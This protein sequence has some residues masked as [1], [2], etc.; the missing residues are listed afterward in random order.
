MKTKTI[1]G[2]YS[3]GYS[4]SAN[5][6]GLTVAATG[7]IGGTGLLV[8]NASTVTNFGAIEAGGSVGANGA[9]FSAGGT[10]INEAGGLILG[11]QGRNGAGGGHAGYLGGAALVMSGLGLIT[12]Y[13]VMTGGQGGAGASGGVGGVGGAGV[14][15]AAG[16]AVINNYEIIGGLGGAGATTGTRG[17]GVALFG[18][19]LVQNGAAADRTA[20]IAGG[21][22]VSLTGGAVATVVN[23]G[24]ITGYG[25]TAVRFNSANDVLVA[26]AGSAFVGAVTGG[27]GTL[28]LL[29]G[30]A[31]GAVDGIS[32]FGAVS[33]A[34]GA[35]WTFNGANTIGGGLGVAGGTVVLA[36]TISDGGVGT[37]AVNFSSGVDRLVVQ[38]GGVLVGMAVGDGATGTLELAGGAG[39][40]SGLGGAGTLSGGDIGAFSGF[41]VYQVDAGAAWS[42]AGSNAL[43]AGQTLTDIGA[44]TVYGMLSNAG[45]IVGG[46]G[47]TGIAGDV[48]HAAGGVGSTALYVAGAG[49]RKSVV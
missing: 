46:A 6:S 11:G 8:A 48:G 47:V 5:F 44:V 38:A 4:L 17:A 45:A 20:L 10:I 33:F 36:G 13:G 1:S 7:S 19:G 14:S 16:G 22:G 27:G 34:S 12:N 43:A 40:I 49:D 41:G 28:Q 42:L 35:K 21:L 15:I 3:A 31:G 29:A 32:G 25:G 26:E 30:S 2:T 23:Y 24:T 9:S 39:T 18:G 37:T